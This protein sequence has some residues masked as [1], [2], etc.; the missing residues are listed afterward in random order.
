MWMPP[1]ASMINQRFELN[2]GFVERGPHLNVV[3]NHFLQ[4]LYGM[5]RHKV[6]TLRKDRSEYPLSGAITV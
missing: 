6:K 1:T 4:A 2:A 5:S 3:G